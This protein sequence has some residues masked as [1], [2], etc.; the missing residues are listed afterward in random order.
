MGG[1]LPL[2][3]DV[4]DRKLLLNQPE[5]KTVRQ[6]FRLYTELG[7]VRRVKEEL[8]RLGIVTKRRVQKNGKRTGG[9][10][11]SRGNLNQFLS[12]PIYVGRIPHKGETYLG[13][14]DTIIDQSLWETTQSLLTRNATPRTQP[15]NSNGSFLLSGKIY[16]ENGQPLYQSQSRKNDKRYCYYISKHLMHE[17]HENSDGWCI[18]AKVMEDTVMVP[19]LDLLRS[20]SRLMDLKCLKDSNIHSIT[21]LKVQAASLTH[22]LEESNPEDK[23]DILQSVIQCIDL[24]PK[25]I[26]LFLSKSGLAKNPSG[27]M[28][29]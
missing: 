18:P 11:F 9:S 6:I 22:Q 3:Y 19:L 10:P 15:R 1:T 2:G 4:K 24:G 16:D 8:D 20:Q 14:H 12:N 23:R 7:T 25:S 21:K 27:P 17:A 13:E 29:R 28:S 26:T 5:A